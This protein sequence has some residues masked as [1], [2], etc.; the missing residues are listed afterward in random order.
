MRTGRAEVQA[1]KMAELGGVTVAAV[2]EDALLL[3]LTTA[4]ITTDA[5]A[6]LL[7]MVPT[8]SYS[9]SNFA[10]RSEHDPQ[11]C[12]LGDCSSS[13]SQCSAPLRRSQIDGRDYPS[14]SAWRVRS[15]GEAVQE[16][17]ARTTC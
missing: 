9:A 2:N 1:A 15:G 13:G 3:R 6:L 12:W 8:L 4:E 17:P 11:V 5:G 10:S 16:S 7:R 14:I